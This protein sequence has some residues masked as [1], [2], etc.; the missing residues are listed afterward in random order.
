MIE[1]EDPD[2]LSLREIAQMMRVHYQTA[3]ELARNDQI[4]RLFKFKGQYRIA[5]GDF[6]AWLRSRQVA[7]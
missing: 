3:W 6:Y 7:G 4:P 5:R 1:V 2:Y